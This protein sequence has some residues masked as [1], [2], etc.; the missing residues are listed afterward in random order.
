MQCESCLQEHDGSF[1]S[2]RFCCSRCAHSFVTKAKRKEINEK[3]SIT[4]KEIYSKDEILKEKAV[5]N[6]MNWTDK[7]RIKRSESLNKKYASLPFNEL[8]LRLR[9]KRILSEQNFKC[10]LCNIE[11]IW[12]NKPLVFHLDHIN[13][14]KL[15]NNRE[16]LRFI[17]PNCHSQTETYAGR[18]QSEEGKKKHGLFK[19]MVP[20]SG[21]EPEVGSLEFPALDD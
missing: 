16:N 1:G 9:K 13:G 21:F 6:L 14:N 17:C 20:A 11:Q 12:N 18:N 19:N 7:A 10:A 2:G 5:R 3:V 4:L 15:D 8:G